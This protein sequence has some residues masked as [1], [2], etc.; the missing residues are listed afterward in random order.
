MYIFLAEKKTQLLQRT[1]IPMVFC[2]AT[3]LLSTHPR[4]E[5]CRKFE[6]GSSAK[7]NERQ[8]G[9][10]RQ[11]NCDRAI[12]FSGLGVGSV[13]VCIGDFLDKRAMLNDFLYRLYRLLRLFEGNS[14]CS[15]S[16]NS[17]ILSQTFNPITSMGLVY[18]P[19]FT[20]KI[21]QM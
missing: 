20:I 19:T 2:E 7:W 5:H 9:C 3:P 13:G 8:L 12:R 21:N 14:M 18:L 4:L 10:P 11:V 1:V 15:T 16:V 17:C 6:R